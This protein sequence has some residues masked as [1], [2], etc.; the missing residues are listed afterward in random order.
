MAGVLK[1]RC[2]GNG[3]T[4][5]SAQQSGVGQLGVSNNTLHLSPLFFELRLKNGNLSFRQEAHM[6]NVYPVTME[7]RQLFNKVTTYPN[8][9]RHYASIE[10]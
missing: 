2:H 8:S 5:I 3:N 6:L 1:Y 10:V 4:I 9:Q 7:T